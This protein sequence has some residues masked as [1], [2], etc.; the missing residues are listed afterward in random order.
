[1]EYHIKDIELEE[2]PIISTVECPHGVFKL[3]IEVRQNKEVEIIPIGPTKN[4]INAAEESL[5]DSDFEDLLSSVSS[6]G[7]ESSEMY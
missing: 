1:M 4:N 6:F 5:K 2:S 3:F 7:I